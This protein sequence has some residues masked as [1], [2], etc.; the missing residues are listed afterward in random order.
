MT[1]KGERSK[2]ENPH[3]KSTYRVLNEPFKILGILDWRYAFFSAVPAIFAGLFT[4]SRGYGFLVFCVVFCVLAW[5]AYEIAS[6]D[7]DL[8]LVLWATLF[9]KKHLSSFRE[10]RKGPRR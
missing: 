1:V 9:D 6:Q 3:A 4:R 7:A 10:E 5:R 8:P 2:T